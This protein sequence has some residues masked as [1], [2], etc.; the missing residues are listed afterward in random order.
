M[1]KQASI[2]WLLTVFILAGGS[3]I[4]FSGCYLKPGVVMSGTKEPATPVDSQGFIHTRSSI[5]G[6]DIVVF[7][8]WQTGE[9][10][11]HRVK[12]VVKSGDDLFYITKGDANRFS[13]PFPVN[14]EEITGK[15]VLGVPYLGRLVLLL[16]TPA[17][18][19]AS[20]IAAIFL[21]A[22]LCYETIRPQLQCID[23]M[24]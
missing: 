7:R 8:D 5:A 20:A 19:A 10:I 3:G 2:F 13:D 21:L 15:V 14:L 12:R 17:G 1:K 18:T 6:G 22:L 9:H 16:K 4:L 11:C 23:S 24:P